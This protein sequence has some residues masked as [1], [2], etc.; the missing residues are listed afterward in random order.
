VSGRQF[1]KLRTEVKNAG[2]V[3]GLLFGLFFALFTWGYDALVLSLNNAYLP[4]AK[5]VTGLPAALLIAGLAGRIAADLPA[6]YPLAWLLA[7]VLLGI[8]AALIQ[9][10]GPNLAVQLIDDRFR[11]EP[12]FAL[13]TDLT[14]IILVIL[15]GAASGAIIGFAGRAVV[16]RAKDGTG[17]PSLVCLCLLLA[18]FMG[19]PMDELLNRPRR[20]LFQTTSRAVR[21]V[22]VGQVS[23]GAGIDDSGYRALLPFREQLEEQYR[24]HYVDSSTDAEG[25]PF[26][27][28]DVVFETGPA[29]RC[30]VAEKGV[31]YCDDFSRQLE[32]WMD[33]LVRAGLYGERVWEE[34][35]LYSLTVD[36]AVV[37][38]LAAH[39][40]QLSESYVTRRSGQWGDQI[41][42]SA[43]F[44]SG[45]SI[46][47]RFRDVA[48]V[49]VD[50][51]VATGASES[52]LRTPA[53]APGRA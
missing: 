17:L 37:E 16:R 10:G 43:Q 20:L 31:L 34:T 44:D 2:T 45:F 40:E 53:R 22:M 9:A 5:L 19:R 25:Q 47:C 36:N 11:G 14:R 39:E 33:G 3:Y 15:I 28:V 42:V 18:F 12:V 51:C 38:W 24:L 26:A 8:A 13:D 30:A 35:P 48:P 50:I 7:G 23:K 1:L 32:S 4:W 46:E 6:L 29:L 41:W 21:L 49:R 27:H 52:N